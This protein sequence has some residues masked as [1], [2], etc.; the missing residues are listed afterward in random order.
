MALMRM[1][2]FSSSG[3]LPSRP[4]SRRKM[5]IRNSTSFFGREKFSVEN[6]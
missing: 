1:P 6:A 3:L 2:C 5:P 4:N